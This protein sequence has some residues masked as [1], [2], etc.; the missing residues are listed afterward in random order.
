MVDT[1][2]PKLSGIG[3]TFEKSILVTKTFYPSISLT[4]MFSGLGGALGLWL[5]VGILQ[6]FANCVNVSILC[7]KINHELNKIS[8]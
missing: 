2:S 1:K 7:L 3:L 5:G 4:K 8:I 6:L